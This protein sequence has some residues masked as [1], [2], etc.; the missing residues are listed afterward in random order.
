MKRNLRFASIPLTAVFLVFAGCGKDRTVDEYQGQKLNQAQH[1]TEDSIAGTYN[2]ALLSKM[3]GEAMGALSIEITGDTDIPDP[4]STSTTGRNGQR[5]AIAAE[6]TLTTKDFSRTISAPNGIYN[7]YSHA[8]QFDFEFENGQFDRSGKAAIV[9]F[10]LAGKIDPLKKTMTGSI[11]AINYAKY[12]GKY[13]LTRDGNSPQLEDTRLPTERAAAILGNTYQGLQTV[14]GADMLVTLKMARPTQTPEGEFLDLFY[15]L[16][17][18]TVSIT[19]TAIK[20]GDDIMTIPFENSEWDMD[21]RMLTGSMSGTAGNGG[22]Q[23]YHFAI[24]CKESGSVKTPAWKC[25]WSGTTAFD[26]TATVVR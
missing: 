1:E 11:Q 13:T 25:S 20:Y 7:I 9:K 22:T 14:T 16:R 2:G 10:R 19:L 4:D 8:Y 17:F 23:P 12:G 26:F 18:T 21:S 6:I 3:N 24:Q 15:P 5:N